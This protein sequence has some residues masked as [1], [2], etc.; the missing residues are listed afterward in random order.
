MSPAAPWRFLAVA[1]AVWS[2][3]CLVLSLQPVYDDAS[4]V[5]EE[6]LL[7]RWENADDQMQLV[8]ERGEWRSYRIAFTERGAT[9]NL[10]GNLSSIGDKRTLFMDVTEMRGVD[11]GPYL[12]P[13]HGLFRVTVDAGELTAAPLDFD[14]FMQAALEKRRGLPALAL[15][16]RRNVIVAAPTA[17]F[18]R[19]LARAPAVAFAAPMTFKR[20]SN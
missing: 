15:D 19:W 14:W 2:Q 6:A 16:D 7:G 4:L 12:L 8:I 3:G 1:V 9:R 5:F 20:A 13:V 10:N 18:R 17:E 11:P